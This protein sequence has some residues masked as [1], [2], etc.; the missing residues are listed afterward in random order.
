MQLLSFAVQCYNSADYMEHCV[1]TLLHGG[2]D[3][4]IIIVDDG[5]QKDNTAEIADRLA[6]EHP[7]I[8]KAVH[9]ENGGHGQAVNTGLKNATGLFFKVVDS[10]DWVDP[11]AYDKTSFK[12]KIMR[13]FL[14]IYL[15]FLP[16]NYY[17]KKCIKNSKKYI[18]VETK[19]VGNFTSDKRMTGDKDI[20]SSFTELSFEGKKYPVPIGYK[21]WLEAFYGDYMK[22]PPKEK[23]VSNH[24][25]KAY[26]IGEDNE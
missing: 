8:I 14:K 18:N 17:T 19:R 2:E 16:K 20:F 12:K 7:T 13:F 24:K 26:Y 6:A 5:S 4:E 11:E 3:V 9:Q 10:D 15:K 25:F 22:L 1:E 23:Q 21:K